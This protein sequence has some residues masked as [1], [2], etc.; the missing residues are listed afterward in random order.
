MPGEKVWPHSNRGSETCRNLFRA[1]QQVRADGG[2]EPGVT[3][4]AWAFPWL[5]SL[6]EVKEAK[7]PG[8]PH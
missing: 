4:Q 8:C 5:Q 2:L 1:T 7:R 3:S 6:W